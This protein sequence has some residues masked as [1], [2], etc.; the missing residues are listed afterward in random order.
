MLMQM[1]FEKLAKAALL[2]S[3]AVGLEWAKGSHRAA[4]KL[5]QVLLRHRT[6]LEDLG[7]PK[8]WADSIW[9]VTALEQAHPQVA[10]DREKLEYPWET[11]DGVIRWPARDLPIAKAL[12]AGTLAPRILRFA[13]L[14]EQKFDHM[15]P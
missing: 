8:V 6:L 4:S 14:L 1:F 7:G 2:R 15:F 10:A 9:V 12:G 11:D 13:S 5:V 3:G